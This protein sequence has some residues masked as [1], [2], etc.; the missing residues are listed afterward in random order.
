MTEKKSHRDYKYEKTGEVIQGNWKDIA[1]TIGIDSE[2][3]GY[4]E[5]TVNLEVL[6][7]VVVPER[8][9]DYAEEILRDAIKLVN[10]DGKVSLLALDET[11]LINK[12]VGYLSKSTYIFLVGVSDKELIRQ[13]K[14]LLRDKVKKAVDEE[15]EV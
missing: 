3:I 7:K 8:Y 1:E 6:P 14:S 9:T 11:S 12:M 10:K 4:V 13:M 5:H 15:T 2:C